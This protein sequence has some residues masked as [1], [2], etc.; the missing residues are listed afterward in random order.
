MN[1]VIFQKE[2]FI[3]SAIEGLNICLDIIDEIK[4]QFHLDFDTSFS[5]HTVIVESVENA[6]LHGNK[7]VKELEV[8]ILIEMT[9]EE[10]F[11][12]VEDQGE[13]FD[14]NSMEFPRKM[15]NITSEGGRGI[16]FI[17]QLSSSCYTIGKG[18]II[19]IKLK[20]QCQYPI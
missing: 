5:L 3:P 1:N 8:R 18:N 17:K 13:G 20:K 19:R 4:E 12:E 15:S 7:G 9:E 10:I 6:I 14:L 11:L 16:F 2:I